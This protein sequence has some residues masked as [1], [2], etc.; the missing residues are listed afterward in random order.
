[1]D[2]SFLLSRKHMLIF[3]HKNLCFLLFINTSRKNI[4]IWKEWSQLG[5]LAL[6]SLQLD[7]AWKGVALL[8]V[9]GYM[10][11]STCSHNPTENEAVVAELLRRSKGSME[12]VDAPLDG[13]RVRPGISH[14]KVLAEEKSKR[15]ISNEK[16]RP[17]RCLIFLRKIVFVLSHSHHVSESSLET[18]EKEQCENEETSCRM[19]RKGERWIPGGHGSGWS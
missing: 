11:Y 6:H 5:A 9:G 13:F 2:P 12:L 16:V 3:A 8:K 4:G 17:G 19:G 15:Q 10:V 18:E 1:M 7:I 14:W